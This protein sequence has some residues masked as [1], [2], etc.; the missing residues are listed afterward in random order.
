M[1]FSNTCISGFES[2]TQS[3][4]KKYIYSKLYQHYYSII[5]HPNNVTL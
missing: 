5:K 1:Y 2:T 4:Y 3:N